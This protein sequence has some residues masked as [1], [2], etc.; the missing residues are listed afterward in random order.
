[1]DAA[2]CGLGNRMSHALHGI[3]IGTSRALARLTDTSSPSG[4]E[5]DCLAEE[6]FDVA[7][8]TAKVN[9]HT[10]SRPLT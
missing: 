8:A 10:P 5:R 7:N 4:A 1:M 2:E 9:P 6:A 3:W